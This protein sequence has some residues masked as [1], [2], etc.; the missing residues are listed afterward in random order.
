MTITT[1]SVSTLNQRVRLALEA[2]FSDIWVEGEISNLARPASGHLYFSLKDEAAQVSCAL[3]KGSRYKLRIPMGEIDNGLAVRAHGR[4]S[5]YEARGSYQLIIDQLE[6]AGLGVL[7]Q[8]FLQRREAL[9]KEGL[10]D[11]RHKQAIPTHPRAIGIITSVSG[12]ALHDALTTLKRRNPLI[13]IIIYPSMVQGESAPGQLIEQIQLANVRAE[14]DV[15]L[16]IRGGGSLEDLWA[17]NDVELVRA[18]VASQIPI[19]SGVG[20]EVDVT[21]SDLAADLRA[22]TPTAAAEQ[23]CVAMSDGIALLTQRFLRIKQQI[24]QLLNGWQQQLLHLQQRL[25]QQNPKRLI[26]QQIQSCD[27]LSMRLNQVMLRYLR[28]G[29]ERLALWQERLRPQMLMQHIVREQRHLQVVSGQL[30]QAQRRHQAQAKQTLHYLMQT[31]YHLSPLN[32]LERGFAVVQGNQQQV[33]TRAEE[34]QPGEKI[35]VRLASGKLFCD[36]IRRRL[37]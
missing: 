36:V 13:P 12:A 1:Y 27:D 16:L 11:L 37:K 19:I 28:H 4:V 33:I 34:V 18:I 22:P 24:Q 9:A 3:F 31:L 6:L 7:E 2:D 26:E 10:F 17:F 30:C 32:V 15:L 25:M 23:V 14:C 5:L 35:Q 29:N 21:L 20:H 8:A